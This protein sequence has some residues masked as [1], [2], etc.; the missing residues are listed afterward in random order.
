MQKVNAIIP[1]FV[2][3]GAKRQKSFVWL[4]QKQGQWGGNATLCR[5]YL[6]AL[7]L[8]ILYKTFKIKMLSNILV[9][10]HGSC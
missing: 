2:S 7:P 10:W 6:I 3:R 5:L 1:E 9:F 8:F 4:W